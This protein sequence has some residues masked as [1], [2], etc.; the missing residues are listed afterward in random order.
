MRKLLFTGRS[1]ADPWITAGARAVGVTQQHQAEAHCP[2]GTLALSLSLS[3]SH[4]H[5]LTV[6]TGRRL[7]RMQ[8]T[9]S[10]GRIPRQL[11][12]GQAVAGRP[13]KSVEAGAHTRVFLDLTLARK[14]SG[15]AL[16]GGR[17]VL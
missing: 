9:A 4:T 17:E 3:L 10:L 6:P 2:E 1:A 16:T 13:L 7:S 15:G 8:P 12:A 14:A 5:T 11:R